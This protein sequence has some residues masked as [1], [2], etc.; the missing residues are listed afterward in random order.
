[1]KIFSPLFL[2]TAI[3]V[4][5]LTAGVGS[6]SAAIISGPAVA[7]ASVQLD[8]RAAAEKVRH[9][10]YRRHRHGRRY[11]R[12]YGSYRHFHGGYWYSYPW[13]ALP[14]AYYAPPRPRYGRCGRW[15][16]ACLNN[17]GHG[18]NYRGCMRY[19]GC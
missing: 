1:M 13:W 14:P 10:R 5:A 19:H 18:P 9:R 8:E 12:R 15:H 2:A 16:R 17:W 7:G 11:R 4:G 3:G 6:A